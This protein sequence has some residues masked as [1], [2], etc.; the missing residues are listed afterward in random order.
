MGISL[1]AGAAEEGDAISMIEAICSADESVVR[2]LGLDGTYPEMDAILNVGT[3]EDLSDVMMS[4]A[5]TG[6]TESVSWIDR[7]ENCLQADW[8]QED[9]AILYLVQIRS[10]QLRQHHPSTQSDLLSSK[11]QARTRL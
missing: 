6:S 5:V 2:L 11:A 9:P 3:I 4:V 7:D 1:I 8:S 10:T